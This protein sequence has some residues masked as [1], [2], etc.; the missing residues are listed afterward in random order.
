MSN[1]DTTGIPRNEIPYDRVVV[2]H[3][4]GATVDDH[5]FPWLSEEVGAERVAMPDPEHPDADVWTTLVTEAIG[6]LTPTTAVVAHSL[7][8]I[9]AVRAINRLAAADPSSRLGA[10][11]AVSPFHRPVPPVTDFAPLDAFI[12]D[13]GLHLFLDGADVPAAAPITLSRTV[14]R[15]DDDPIIPAALSDDFAAALDARVEIVPGAGHFLGGDGHTRLDAA[16]GAL[17]R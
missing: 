5:W 16:L 13:G 10:L 7:G 6:A 4:F 9:T 15:S 11:V 17:R 14:I 3:G 2:V 12:V 8:C 1:S